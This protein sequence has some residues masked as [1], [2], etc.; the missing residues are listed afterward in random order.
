KKRLHQV[1]QNLLSNAVK[2]IG[3][4]NPSPRIYVGVKR[5]DNQRVFFV[6]DNGI[7]IE[8]R[9]FE[10]IFQ[11]FQRLPSAKKMEEGTGVG[12]TIV[13]QVIGKHGGRIW[14]NS[15]PGTGTSFFF[16]L[17]DPRSLD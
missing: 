15:V 6:R 5:Q 7:G 3:E 16:T 14:V 1:M 9:Y 2:Y 17:P 4:D 10:L 11:V 13:K 12:L 8:E